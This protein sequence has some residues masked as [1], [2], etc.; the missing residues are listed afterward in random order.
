MLRDKIRTDYRRRTHPAL[1]T[2]LTI[3]LSSLSLSCGLMKNNPT[4]QLGNT[5][6]KTK[7]D[8]DAAGT[9]KPKANR[10]PTIST[11]SS[12]SAKAADG[13]KIKVQFTI[14]DEDGELDCAQSMAM[15]SSNPTLLPIVNVVFAGTYPNC[16]A[17]LAPASKQSGNSDVTFVVSDGL[18][19]AETSFSISIGIGNKPPVVSGD[20][21]KYMN[22]NEA[23]PEFMVKVYDQD[24]PAG[25]CDQKNLFSEITAAK[26]FV[27][28]LTWGGQWPDCTVK[29]IPKTDF[30]GFIKWN[31]WASDGDAQGAKSV[32]ALYVSTPPEVTSIAPAAAT[33]T[34]KA[35]PR[36]PLDQI[37]VRET[38]SELVST[39]TL[40][41]EKIC[42]AKL[43]QDYNVMSGNK[44]WLPLKKD[45]QFAVTNFDFISTLL[46]VRFI[47]NKGVITFRIPPQYAQLNC[48]KEI[49]G[50]SPDMETYTVAMTDVDFYAESTLTNKVCTI[51]EGSFAKD[52]LYTEANLVQVGEN[53]VSEFVLKPELECTTP[54]GKAYYPP[55]D[56]LVRFNEVNTGNARILRLHLRK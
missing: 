8:S 42:T 7:S 37:Q 50:K 34:P 44:V 12:Q 43:I 52:Q 10:P 28:E 15:K 32:Y 11:I 9:E 26:E 41:P 55:I 21:Y 33:A 1:R 3:A 24:S 39:R 6:G 35:T 16:T 54:S 23:A 46:L 22:K 4:V 14:M 51:K 30:T 31:V 29:V 25:A 18:L 5:G 19:P 48:S 36:P 49:Y 13:L 47:E 56:P 20:R 53:T 45:E 27:N 38:I 40:D 2:C 17:E